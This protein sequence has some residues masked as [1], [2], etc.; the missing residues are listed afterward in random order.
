MTERERKA[1]LKAA[2]TVKSETDSVLKAIN[3]WD[4]PIF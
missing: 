3:L 4:C 1:F 2:E